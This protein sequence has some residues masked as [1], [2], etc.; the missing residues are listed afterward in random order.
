[1]IFM[2]YTFEP[3]QKFAKA[4]GSNVNV[5]TKSSVIICRVIRNK[6]LTRSRRLLEGLVNGTRNLDGKRYTNTAQEILSLVNSCEKNAEFLG[7]DNERLFVHASAHMGRIVQR[8][9]RKAKFGSRIKSTNIQIMLIE[10]GKERKTKISKK[11]IKERVK[12]EET[13]VDKEIKK[14]QK[15]LKKEVGEL[16]KKEKELAEEEKQLEQSEK[17]LEQ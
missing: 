14:E 13:D 8:R 2:K 15:Q 1:M 3:K 6:P 4:Y 10:R 17:Q 16:Q 9:R 12:K 7:L 5:S 11:Q